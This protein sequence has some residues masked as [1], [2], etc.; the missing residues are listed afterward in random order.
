MTENTDAEIDHGNGRWHETIPGRDLDGLHERSNV[1]QRRVLAATS[2]SYVV[3]LLD[4]SIIN[5]ALERISVSLGTDIGGLQWV[6]NAYTLEIG[7]A[8]V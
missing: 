1:M 2:V 8:H 3:V 4:T 7:R 5:V 6:M